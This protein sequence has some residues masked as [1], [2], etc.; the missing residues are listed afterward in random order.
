MNKE[1]QKI[2][3]KL[4]IG[5]PSIILLLTVLGLTVFAILSIRA[6]YSGLKLAR[7]SR[8]SIAN[9]YL[10]DAE[11]ERIGYEIREAVSYGGSVA[12]TE[13]I[14]A[15]IA[16]VDAVENGRVSYS[17][18]L[19]D[20]VELQVVL[21]GTDEY[22]DMKVVSHRLMTTAEEDFTESNFGLFDPIIIE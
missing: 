12:D 1:K 17:V 18:E 2:S 15:D 19:N 6:A 4:N 14:I 21:E 9:Y 7:T 22:R 20:A 13:A 11:A 16:G 8:E 3:F 10:C 5:G